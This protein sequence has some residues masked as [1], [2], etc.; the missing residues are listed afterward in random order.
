MIRQFSDALQ[1]DEGG[2]LLEQS[3]IEAHRHFETKPEGNIHRIMWE[4]NFIPGM[5]TLVKRDCFTQAGLYDETLF[6]EDWDMWLRISR[7]FEFAY[8]NEV[9]A[10]Y[11]LVT[12]SMVRS[13]YDRMLEAMCKICLK[14]L[15]EGKLDREARHLAVS[16]L[17]SKAL[18]C[19]RRKTPEHKRYLLRALRYGPSAGVLAGCLFAWSGLGF[20][21]YARTHAFF[22]GRSSN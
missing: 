5:A 2:K 19:F 11:R 6:Y 21:R 7:S 22:R 17:E 8:S 20:D 1:M 13:Q 15:R 16:Q 3:F 4:G 14:H 10:K 9:S 18:A 12:T